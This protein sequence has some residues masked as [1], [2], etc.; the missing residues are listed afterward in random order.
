MYL[1]MFMVVATRD[2]LVRSVMV[3]QEPFLRQTTSTDQF[4]KLLDSLHVIH[5]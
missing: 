2:R 5:V 3:L 4:L 1:L